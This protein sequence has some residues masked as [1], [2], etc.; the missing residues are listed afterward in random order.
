MTGRRPSNTG[1]YDNS[2]PYH[3]AA[4][5]AGVVTLNQHMKN[6]GY[7]TLGC[8][9][10]YHGTW[11]GFA[12]TKGW[13]DYGRPHVDFSL[14]GPKPRAGAAAQG[15]FDWGP[16]AN[17]DSGMNDYHVAEW[18][19]AHLAKKQDKPMFLACGIFRP[20]LPWYVPQKYF[21]MYPLDKIQL[22]VV[23]ED[24]LDDVPATGKRFA[25]A[26]GDHARVTKA[27]AWKKGVQ[28]YMASITFSDAMVGR[29]LR[30]LETGPHASN[31]S[32]VLWSDHG[33]H[34]GEKLHWR[35]FTLW[36][37][38]TRNVLMMSIPGVTRPGGVCDRPTSMMDIYP[39]LMELSG[40]RAPGVLDGKSLVPWL[41]NPKAPRPDPALTT[42]GLGNHAIRSEQWR[43]IRYNDGGEEL[44]DRTADPNEWTNLAG[45]PEFA[46]VKE[47]LAKW[48]PANNEPDAPRRREGGE[49]GEQ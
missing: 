25:K 45:K 34:L 44:Y 14:P 22:P 46:K 30:A 28:A 40:L 20:H 8:G 16:T 23:K 29:V 19:S 38:S 35:K 39:T 43:Y 5:L 24:D 33:W 41:K 6:S 21:D 9:K 27:D 31:T 13:D 18:V 1:V 12:D 4:A 42:Y 15:H 3:G 17:D 47:G 32:V 36:E 49:P 2:Q 37:R 48:L 7:L 10:I 11:G 26:N